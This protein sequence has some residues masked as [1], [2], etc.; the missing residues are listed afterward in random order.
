MPGT[1]TFVTPG[2]RWGSPNVR[3]R[4]SSHGT[5]SK[6]SSS[7]CRTKRPTR[8][9]GVRLVRRVL[10]SRTGVPPGYPPSTSCFRP[11]PP[12]NLPPSSG[13]AAGRCPSRNS[14]IPRSC[15]LIG[16]HIDGVGGPLEQPSGHRWKEKLRKQSGG[17]E[18][19]CCRLVEDVQRGSDGNHYHQHRQG[20]G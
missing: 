3:R 5:K 1:Q 18:G 4:G 19:C 12:D 7:G 9:S 15:R 8:K 17:Q 11:C 10:L 2:G 6:R 16:D 20:G 14:S 13:A